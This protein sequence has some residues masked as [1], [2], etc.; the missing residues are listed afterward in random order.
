MLRLAREL[1]EG[2][3]LRIEVAHPK[4][5]GPAEIALWR[6]HQAAD[7]NL[8]SP[9]LTPEWAQI[10]GAEREDARVCVIDG[11]RGFLG[12]QR[13]SRYAAMG[14]GAPIAD[15]QGVVGEAGLV[16]DGSAICRALGVGRIDLTHVPEGQRVLGARAAGGEGSW[17][18][19]VSSGSGAYAAAIKE[20]RPEFVRQIDKKVRKLGRERESMKFTALSIDHGHFETMLHW[21][22]QQLA[23]TGQPR[24]WERAWVRRV[25]DESFAARSRSFSGAFFTLTVDGQL[26]A[27]N[28]FLRSETVLHDWIMAHDPAF[29]AYSPGVQLARWAVTWAGDKG[30]R[31]VDF[32]PGEYQYKRQLATGQRRLE[33][34]AVS[35]ASWSGAVR[36]AQYAVRAGVE[37]LPYPR[38]AALPGKAM[39]K[40]DLI[41]ALG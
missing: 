41:R 32:G 16:A 21:K 10:I 23:R 38:I 9:Y 8:A 14:L 13:Q 20:R 12:V 34:G 22:N 25:L 3:P 39:R 5:L 24:I 36:R 27:A 31:E 11:G 35:G 33:W 7:S 30:L 40:F 1:S 17:I 4:E 29:D 15:Y 37:R 26:V 18:A 19:D 28:Y 2:G 6:A